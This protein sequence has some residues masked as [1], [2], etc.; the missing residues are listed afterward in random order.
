MFAGLKQKTLH[1]N[2]GP[3][4][5]FNTFMRKKLIKIRCAAN[6]WLTA[7]VIIGR[8]ALLWRVRMIKL[9]Y[10]KVNMGKYKSPVEQIF[11][12][13]LML[14]K[15]CHYHANTPAKTGRKNAFYALH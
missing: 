10:Y 12:E 11:I 13:H 3:K 5:A 4:S 15:T 7:Y 14:T 9:L 8:T 6:I 2:A 1:K